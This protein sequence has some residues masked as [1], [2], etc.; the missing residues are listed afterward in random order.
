LQFA[1]L[2]GL[3]ISTVVVHRQT[4]FAMN[5]AL[6]VDPDNVYLIAHG[7]RNAFK[8][9][10]RNVPGVGAVACS[11]DLALKVGNSTDAVRLPDGTVLNAAQHPV[12]L[13][14]F[15]VY[16]LKPVAGRFFRA[17]HPGDAVPEDR[18]AR[19]AAPVVLNETAARRFGF[20][21]ATDAVGRT[22]VL[23]GYENPA[24]S[25]IIGIVPDF[26]MDPVRAQIA[27]VVYILD[28]SRSNYIAVKL[29][30]EDIPGTLQRIRGVWER[31]AR[32]GPPDARFLEQ[33]IFTF[34]RDV[35]QRESMFAWFSAVAVLIS[36]AGLF[37]L[38][39]HTAARRTKEI[40]IR[41]ATGAKVG[42]VLRLI[43]WE[44]ARPVL[45]ANLLA[46]PVVYWALNRWL[47]GFAYHIDLELWMFV[48]AGAVS[49]VIALATVSVHSWTVAQARP[50]LALRYE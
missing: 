32:Y 42:D 36:A 44:F 38:A 10:V 40:G 34:V 46:W 31:S 21:S 12:D 43:G 7:C 27:P 4:Q 28:P 1:V 13:G 47:S 14:F 3:L 5:E 29:T 23:T 37:G 25:E 49:L 50:I 39:A 9:D 35:Q 24:P 30:G 45:L 26:S 48:G 11:S 18:S 16:G 8:N 33:H 41:K 20:A 22:I 15:E 2:T 6:R 17:D 19:M